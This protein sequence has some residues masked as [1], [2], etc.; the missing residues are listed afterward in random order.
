[1]GWNPGTE[2]EIF[3]MEEL[4][5]QFDFD[6]INKAGAKF[7]LN[8]ARWFNHQ[9][10]IEKSDEELAEYVLPIMKEKINSITKEEIIRPISLVKER[11][12]F[13][14]DFENQLSFFF[15]APETYDEG[16]IKKRWKDETPE[17]LNEI[18]SIL[19]STLPFDKQIAHQVVSNHI[20][21]KSWNMGAVMNCLRLSIVGEA[22]GPDL[23]EIIDIIG[24][25]ESINRIEKAIK[26]IVK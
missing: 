9:Y 7:D 5:E 24:V 1:M 14:S 6:R 15:I 23:F 17:Q 22:K 4:V 11:C 19:K 25:E 8:K 2:Q 21:E 16:I 26:T 13:P 10:L 20:K 18:V 3:T 12:N